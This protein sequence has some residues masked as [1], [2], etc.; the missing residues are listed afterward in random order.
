MPVL[1]LQLEPQLFKTALTHGSWAK[2]NKQPSYERLE[3]LGDAVLKIAISDFLYKEFPNSKEGELTQFRALIVS[4]IAIADF[5]RKIELGELILLSD[6]EKKQGGAEKSSILACAF[7]AVL[8]AI[9]LEKGLKAASDFILTNFKNE[10]LEL[11]KTSAN[12]NYKA[13]LQ[14][15]TQSKT[16]ELPVYSTIKETGSDHNK[17]FTVQVAYGD[18]VA[19]L[20]IGKSKKEAQQEAARLALVE[21]GV[22]K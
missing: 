22:T 4:D 13:T 15:F 14:E 18:K 6:G 3:F 7:E 21:L 12:S 19:A 1:G 5:A 11:V 20:G 10:I 8:G 17:T 9:F 16:N 2:E